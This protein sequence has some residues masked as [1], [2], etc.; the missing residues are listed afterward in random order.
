ME[1]YQNRVVEEQS[2]LLQKIYKLDNFINN[3]NFRY[4]DKDDR[5]LLSIQRDVMVVY[6]NIL[7]RRINNWENSE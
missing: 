6:A 4:L 5:D 2:E 1:E 3:D 7:Q